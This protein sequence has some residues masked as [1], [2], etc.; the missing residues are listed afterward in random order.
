MVLKDEERVLFFKLWLELLTFV[1]NEYG[2]IKNFGSPKTPV[3]LNIDD[4]K[5]IRDKL[6]EN[7]SVIDKYLK[8][9]NLNQDE[10]EIVNSWKSFLKSKFMVLKNYKKYTVIMDFDSEILYG[11]YGI[12]N[13]IV[14]ML[15]PLPTMIETVIIPFKGKIIYDSIFQRHDVILGKN[16]RQSFNEK[17]MEIKNSI[18][19]K[20]M[21]E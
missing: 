7:D 3:G 2:V 14:E 20:S 16:M 19:I 17:Y 9:S 5:K 12:T 13:P 18:G 8:H 10:Y 21:L 15:P 11:I 6:W 1:N 4:I